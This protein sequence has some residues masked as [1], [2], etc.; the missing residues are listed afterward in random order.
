M[1]GILLNAAYAPVAKIASCSIRVYCQRRP[2]RDL[3]LDTHKGVPYPEKL[4]ASLKPLVS[5]EVNPKT[6]KLKAKHEVK[7]A[8]VICHIFK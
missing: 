5:F 4:Q 6:S 1:R 2:M 3:D 8:T 7:S